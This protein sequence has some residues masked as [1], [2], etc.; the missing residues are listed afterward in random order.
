[1]KFSTIL[2]TAFAATVYASPIAEAET[3]D[4]HDVTFKYADDQPHAETAEL[5]KRIE[6]VTM[7]IVGIVGT[8]VLVLAVK[9][10]AEKIMEFG[11]QAQNWNKDREEFLRV[12]VNEFWQANPDKVGFPA[13]ACYNKGYHTKEPVASNGGKSAIWNLTYKKGAFLK[14]D[15]DCMYIDRGNSFYTWAEG[16]FR[17]LR[18]KHTDVCT[19]QQASG[20]LYC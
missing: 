6:P 17:N 1:M 2:L 4:V 11:K 7:T 10:A 9:A 12:S 20:D 15:W 3:V 5:A 18:Y 19:F 14:T 16:G 8:K 13:V